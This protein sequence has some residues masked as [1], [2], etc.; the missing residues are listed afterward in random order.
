MKKIGNYLIP[1]KP[2]KLFQIRCGI[3]RG[4]TVTAPVLRINM[5]VEDVLKEINVPRS[6]YWLS[7][8]VFSV[9]EGDEL[10]RLFKEKFWVEPVVRPSLRLT[11][12][13]FNTI[14]EDIDRVEY[15]RFKYDPG[16][17]EKLMEFL[18]CLSKEH[19]YKTLWYGINCFVIK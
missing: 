16:Q 5:S 6:F 1:S 12:K 2:F 11:K 14:E 8:E 7:V 4:N 13:R 19:N 18:K 10:M 15:F 17:E 3:F 9:E